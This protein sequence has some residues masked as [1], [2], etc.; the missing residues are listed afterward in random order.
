MF[1]HVARLA[2]PT[3][4]GLFELQAVRCPSDFV[5][6]AL[7]AGDLGDGRSVLTRV[8]SECLTGDALGSLRCDCGVQLRAGMRAV[9]AARRGVV[10]YA[11]GHEG[12]GIGLVNKLLAYVH[13]DAGAD[14]VDANL[15]LGLPID[16]RDYAEAAGVLS[17]IGVHSI[18]LLTNNPA[19][20]RG[21]EE[22]GIRVDEIKSL[23]VAPHSRNAR[24][25]GTKLQRL[26][27]HAGTA[28][29]DG[30]VHS[31]P[32][33]EDLLGRVRAPVSRP[34]VVLKYAQSLDGRIATRTGDA[35]WISGEEERTVSHALRARCDGIMVGSGTILNDDPQLTVRM[36]HGVSPLRVIVDSHLRSSPGAQVFDDAAATVAVTTDASEPSKRRLLR[37]RDVGVW[38]LPSNGHGVDLLAALAMLRR[39]GLE[40]LLVEGGAAMITSLLSLHVVDRVIVSIAPR[41]LGA[42][43]EAIGDLGTQRVSE[44]LAL[45]DS[46]VRMAGRD[47]LIAGDVGHR[48]DG[49]GYAGRQTARPDATK[50][51]PASHKSRTAH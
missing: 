28:G 49:D 36:V 6:L 1:E 29:M 4:Y 13:Q 23:S 16:K 8:H 34:Y 45:E 35:K 31:A 9:S 38:V 42:G 40:S 7:I 32:D 44:G 41:L 43:L 2:L 27:H 11:T 18:R 24:Y 46:I 22:A 51:R 33:V 15:R 39:E 20:A 48:S 26:G 50:G 21:L 17:S 19:K 30:R 37:D 5:Y 3:P 12:R 14:T 25:L 10:L 47:L